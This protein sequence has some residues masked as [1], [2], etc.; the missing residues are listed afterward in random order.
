[1]EGDE[2]EYYR[3]PDVVRYCIYSKY[4]NVNRKEEFKATSVRLVKSGGIF[5]DVS[6]V[7]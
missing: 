2:V 5:G 6:K 3:V 1:M 4:H 7:S